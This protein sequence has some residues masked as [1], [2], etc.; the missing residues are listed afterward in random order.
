MPSGFEGLNSTALLLCVMFLAYVAMILTP[1]LREKP[2][3]GGDPEGFEWHFLIPCLNEDRVI[4]RTVSSLIVQNPGAHVWCVDDDSDDDTGALLH[5][6]TEISSHVHVISRR[7]PFARSGKGAALN[8]G[9]HALSRHLGPDVDRSRV[10]VGVLDADGRLDEQAYEVLAGERYFADSSVGAVQVQV[11]MINRGHSTPDADDPAA[12]TRFGRLLVTL[13]DLEFRTVISGMQILRRHTASVGM[14][15]NGQFTRMSTLDLI[16]DSSGTPWHGAL[17]EDFELGVHTLLEGHRTEYAHHT[18]VAQE[19]L[20]SLRPLLRQRSRWAQGAMQCAR[21]LPTI[22][23]SRKVSTPAA[24]EIGYFLLLPW[25]QIVGTL[26]YLSATGVL[27]YYAVTTIGGVPAWF[28]GG[29]WGVIPLVALFGVMPFALWGFV[30]R[31]RCAPHLSRTQALGLGL[32][33]WMYSYAHAVAIWIAFVRVVR[34]RNDWIKTERAGGSRMPA[35]Q[36]VV[37]M[38]AHSG[39]RTPRKAGDSA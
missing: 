17:L 6:L 12:A 22:M 39:T 20:A 33:N 10:I 9:W 13:Q 16:A 7:A 11:R 36:L 31:A 27:C 24:M 21:Y 37:A 1:Y 32:A 18:W 3:P 29:A 15:G 30:Y 19:G 26:V 38:N 35:G 23:K 25:L 8:A 34:S 28:A 5:R 4:V 14:G 2:G